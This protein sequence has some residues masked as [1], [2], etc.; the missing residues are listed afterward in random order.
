VSTLQGIPGISPSM[1]MF[2]GIVRG[3]LRDHAELNR[4]IAGEETNDTM[5]AW[6]IMDALSDFNGTPPNLGTFALDDLLQ[7]NLH[8]LLLRMT[9][10]TILESVGLLQTRNHINYSTGGTNVGLND[11]T[12]MIMNWINLLKPGCEQMK[13]RV[14]TAMNVEGILGASH[15]GVRS[16]YSA[17]NATYLPY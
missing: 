11:K 10:C 8:A 15:S 9:V 16:E 2:I 1:Q 12:P 3:Y 5:I 7:R 13:Q 14:K 17:I 6:A 4:L